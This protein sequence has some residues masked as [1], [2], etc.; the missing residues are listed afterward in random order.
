[1]N[2]LA[3]EDRQWFIDRLKAMEERLIE[4]LRKMQTEI[5][6]NFKTACDSQ[7]IRMRKIEDEK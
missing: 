1:M 6:R 4:Q 2:E 7:T 3:D 5:L